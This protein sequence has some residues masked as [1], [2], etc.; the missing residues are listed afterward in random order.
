[1]LPPGDGREDWRV[2]VDI[3][4]HG[5]QDPETPG[6]PALRRLVARELGL[7]DENLLNQLPGLGLVPEF[8]T[9]TPTGGR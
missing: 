4:V 9:E 2:L 5:G 8:A 3:L 6:L 7:P 1:M